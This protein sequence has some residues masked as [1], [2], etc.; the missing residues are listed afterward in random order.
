MNK[1][2]SLTL[3]F[4]ASSIISFILFYFILNIFSDEF[5]VLATQTSSMILNSIG[6]TNQA[7]DNLIYARNSVA[8]ISGLCSGLLEISLLSAFII[9][10]FELKLKTRIKWMIGAVITILVLNPIRISIS[11]LFLG[12]N[13]VFAVNHDLLFRIMTFSTIVVF[14]GLFVSFAKKNK[15]KT[16]N[17]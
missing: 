1:K 16:I 7:V 8:L 17:N 3:K 15:K 13:Q 9:S 12:N 2:V 6:I 11:I 4:L 5:N 10:S 14:Y